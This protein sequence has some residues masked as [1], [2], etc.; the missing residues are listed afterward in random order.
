MSR[1]I[2]VF[3]PV[4]LQK[5][6]KESLTVMGRVQAGDRQR[7]SIYLNSIL[8]RKVTPSNSGAFECRLDLSS[9]EQAQHAVEIRR[10]SARGTERVQVPFIKA[11]EPS[12]SAESQE[13]L[14]E[15]DI[16]GA[17]ANESL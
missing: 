9:L 12:Q 2:Q 17:R 14:S 5:V 4:H 8:I 15:E 1:K 7:L 16:D 13:E 3:N 10:I 6:K 11:T